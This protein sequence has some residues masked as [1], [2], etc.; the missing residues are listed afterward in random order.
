[1]KKKVLSKDELGFTSEDYERMQALKDME[2]M[3][4][5]TLLDGFDVTEELLAAMNAGDRLAIDIFFIVNEQRIRRLAT[6]FLQKNGYWVS[7]YVGAPLLTVDD[8]YNQA[9]LD[10]RRGFLHFEYKPR[11]LS[12]L[13]CHSFYY[14][15]VGGFGD[16]DGR[17]RYQPRKRFITRVEVIQN[18]GKHVSTF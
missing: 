15:P 12:G 7:S 6:R 1:M 16:E 4:G 13:L 9:Y 3:Q 11:Y 14:A 18:G 5:D 2:G 10:A 17:Y 8:C